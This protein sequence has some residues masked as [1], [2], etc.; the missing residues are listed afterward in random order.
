MK[1][2]IDRII[3]LIKDVFKDNV[4]DL[5]IISGSRITCVCYGTVPM[6]C[7]LVRGQLEIKYGALGALNSKASYLHPRTNDYEDY[8]TEYAEMLL[9]DF[10]K[11][12][13][14]VL[15]DKYLSFYHNYSHFNAPRYAGQLFVTDYISTLENELG[16]TISYII[17]SD[18]VIS[19]I[20]HETLCYQ[21]VINNE[22]IA[23][24]RIL[25]RDFSVNLLTVEKND[26]SFIDMVEFIKAYSD[27]IIPDE[28]L[29][30]YPK[31]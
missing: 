4:S 9:Q 29:Y 6:E 1:L 11:L 8:L 22:T 27:K 5:A 30:K 14:S 20:V 23:L 12:C 13:L 17:N 3:L 21:L 16:S 26:K 15:P 18:N 31:V 10:K 2:N 28:W 25:P 19:F 24:L 7:W